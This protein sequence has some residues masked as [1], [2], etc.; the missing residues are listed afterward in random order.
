[1]SADP[2]KPVIDRYADG[3]LILVQAAGGL[4]PELAREHP[5]EGTWSIAQLVAHV[6]D[7]DL[8]LSDRMKRVI[9]EDSPR[10][11]A[12]DENAWLTRL[13]SGAMPVMEAAELFAAN[14][15]WMT[16]VLRAQDESA[17]A[18][19]GIHSEIGKLTLAEIVVKATHHLDHHLRFLYAKRAKLG[20]SIYPRYAANP[21]F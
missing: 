20:V 13:D 19:S 10:L 18:R 6:L 7:T 2:R 11:E 17:F 9:A 3:G 15:K 4:T 12:F 16:R 21:G 14:R 5:I 1:M 8:V